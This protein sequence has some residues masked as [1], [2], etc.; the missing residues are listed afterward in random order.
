MYILVLGLSN[1]YSILGTNWYQVPKIP[2]KHDKTTLP[3]KKD[4]NLQH[5]LLHHVSSLYLPEDKA[6]CGLISTLVYFYDLRR[7]LDA[8]RSS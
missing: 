2:Y 3:K 6:K 1:T 8:L 4:K 5:C 7:V